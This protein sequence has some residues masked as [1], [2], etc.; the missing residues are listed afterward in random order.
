MDALK[1]GWFSE[2]HN[3]WPGQSMSLEV[4]EV[5]HA[6]KT[7]FQDILIFQSKTY[8]R[9]LALDGVIQCTDRDECS[10]QEMMAHLPL[11]S[12]PNPSKVLVV[13]GGD[14]GVVREVAKHSCVEEIHLCEID[15]RVVEL[16]K[17]Y[18]PQL[19]CGFSDSRVA[20]HYQDGAEFMT[21]HP[22]Q[23]DVIITD[24]SDPIGPAE[25]LFE[26]P[27]YEKMKKA[28]RPGGVLCAQGECIWLDLELIQRVAQHSRAM[29][30]VVRF[31]F[32]SVPTYPC[33]TIGYLLASTN[34]A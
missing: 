29:F 9:V 11:C 15:Q 20:V 25:C 34:E 22:S 32:S 16:S 31:A 21:Q 1:K 4:E 5:L 6:E 2:L 30:P 8:G 28:L 13:G 3:L 27:Y 24:S 33:G 7:Q 17:Q 14:G 10:Y 18:L 12:H 26:Q 19:S 23:F